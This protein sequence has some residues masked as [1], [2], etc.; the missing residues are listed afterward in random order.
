MAFFLRREKSSC[1]VGDFNLYRSS[2]PA[3]VRLTENQADNDGQL[4]DPIN[5][6]GQWNNNSA[7]HS[8]GNDSRHFNQAIN[9]GTNTAVPDSVATALYYAS[10][11]LPV[12]ADFVVG[13]VSAVENTTRELQPALFELRQN[14]PNPFFRT[15]ETEI[16]FSLAQESTVRLEIFDLLGAQVRLLVEKKFPAGKHQVAWNG[17]NNEGQSVEGG[18]YF[19]R[20]QIGHT[21]SKWTA[22][23]KMV[24]LP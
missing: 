7:F 10:D 18:V 1:M 11:H 8:F 6:P 9:A 13:T 24:V 16:H 21:S 20:L 3:F 15:A 14:Y 22:V 23:K 12:C 17:H 2:E 4:F 5:R 19:Y